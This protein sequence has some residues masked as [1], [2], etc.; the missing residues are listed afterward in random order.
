MTLRKSKAWH[1]AQAPATR[2]Y[3]KL[4]RRAR[5]RYPVIVLHGD[6][7]GDD[8]AVQYRR[9]T[10]GPPAET[11]WKIW[12][13]TEHAS[14]AEVALYECERKYGTDRLAWRI[15]RITRV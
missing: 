13:T 5:D 7:I 4:T 2:P 8:Y 11:D 1:G 15:A 14:Q 3:T 12:L 10:D 6:A 9:L